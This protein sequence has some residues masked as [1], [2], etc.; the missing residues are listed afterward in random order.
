MIKIFLFLSVVSISQIA[1]GQKNLEQLLEKNNNGSVPYVYVEDVQTWPEEAVYLDARELPEYEVSHIKDA[2]FVGYNEFN[3]KETT[4]ALVD[5]S[6]PIIVYCSLGVR[7]EDIGEKLKEA[8]Y[9]EVFN[10]YGGIFEWKN[11]GLEIVNSRQ[12]IT[13]K[14]HAFD[15]HW[16]KWLKEGIKVYE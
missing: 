1:V 15:K 9:T 12:E 6:T 14:V 4:R 5:K 11:A 2:I 13:D 10:L 3:L 16:G 7:S 8:G